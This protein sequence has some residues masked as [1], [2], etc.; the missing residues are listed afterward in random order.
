MTPKDYQN[1]T[2]SGEEFHP[3]TILGL[4]PSDVEM[5]ICRALSARVKVALRCLD[6]G[7]TTGARRVLEQCD[8]VLPLPSKQNMRAAEDCV[9]RADTDSVPT[10]RTQPNA[11]ERRANATRTNALRNGSVTRD[12][13]PNAHDAEKLHGEERPS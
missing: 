11:T 6:R 8:R 9:R 12:V 7:D 5:P 4:T 1:P 13:P 2:G 10:E 3:L